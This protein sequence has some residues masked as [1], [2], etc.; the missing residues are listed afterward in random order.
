MIYSGTAAS[1]QKETLY[2]LAVTSHSVSPSSP[3]NTVLS[4]F[5]G[6]HILDLHVH[7]VIQCVLLCDQ[8]ECFQGSSVW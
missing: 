8:T 3:G 1:L 2:P 7:G 4:V 5:M 6:L